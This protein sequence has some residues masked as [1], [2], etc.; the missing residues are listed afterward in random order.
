MLPLFQRLGG[1][2]S[3]SAGA[4]EILLAPNLCSSGCVKQIC[5][6]NPFLGAQ[7]F[8]PVKLE[9]TSYI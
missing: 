7:D 6:F 1:G 5:D 8:E 9:I 4:N 3:A 2:S